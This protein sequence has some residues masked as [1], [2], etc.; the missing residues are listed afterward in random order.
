[1]SEVLLKVRQWNHTNV[2]K[3]K[4]KAGIKRHVEAWLDRE[5]ADAAIEQPRKSR[6]G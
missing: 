2:R 5:D 6:F 4:T 1:V 3:R